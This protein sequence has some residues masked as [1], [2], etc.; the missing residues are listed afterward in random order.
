VLTAFFYF[1]TGHVTAPN[2]LRFKRRDHALVE[3]TAKRVVDLVRL[4]MGTHAYVRRDRLVV[5]QHTL[6]GGTLE[7]EATEAEERFDGWAAEEYA[8]APSVAQ[9]LNPRHLA[10]EPALDAFTVEKLPNG[11]ALVVARDPEPWL[12]GLNPE[13]DVLLDATHAFRRLLPSS[14]QL[15]AL[16]R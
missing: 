5:P 6:Y 3:E 4:P 8:V 16:R 1:T 11:R 7:R 13:P 9:V 12:R 10:K 15:D 14:S 2:G